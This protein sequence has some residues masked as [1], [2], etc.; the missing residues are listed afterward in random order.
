V[1]A[2]PVHGTMSS[3]SQ[4]VAQEMSVFLGLLQQVGWSENQREFSKLSIYELATFFMGQKHPCMFNLKL[5]KD[6]NRSL[7]TSFKVN[8]PMIQ[9]ALRPYGYVTFLTGTAPGADIWKAKSGFKYLVTSQYPV[10]PKSFDFEFDNRFELKWATKNANPNLLSDIAKEIIANTRMD[11]TLVL[12]PSKQTLREIS[13]HF[14]AIYTGQVIIEHEG[15]SI[16][17]IQAYLETKSLGSV[18]VVCSGRFVEGIEF[19]DENGSSLVKRAIVVGVPFNPP[20]EEQSQLEAYYAKRFNWNN[21]DCSRAFTYAPVAS[22]IRQGIGRTVRNLV[23]RGHILFLDVRYS[24]SKL[25]RQ[26]LKLE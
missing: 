26:A 9:Y 13:K 16:D 19:T 8:R 17:E 4:Y 18:H 5:R 7:Q 21:W 24:N 23:D 15:L 6:F 12:Y 1:L 10:V 25:L 22:K 3:D 20:S 2:T 14:D 11:K